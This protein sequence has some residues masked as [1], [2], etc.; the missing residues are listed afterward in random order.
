M[1]R[2][3]DTDKTHDGEIVTPEIFVQPSDVSKDVKPLVSL[4]IEENESIKDAEEDM[5]QF[6]KLMWNQWC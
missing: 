5:E 6:A 1:K 4:E 3:F 2:I